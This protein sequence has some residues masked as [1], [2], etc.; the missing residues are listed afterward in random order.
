MPIFEFVEYSTH[1][2]E[3]MR[4]RRITRADV[5]LVLRIAE[6]RPGESGTWVYERGHVRV[7]VA[8]HST[9]AVVVTVVRLKGKR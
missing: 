3:R 7:I 1:A 6:G 8:E 4:E 2:I 5:E 9:N